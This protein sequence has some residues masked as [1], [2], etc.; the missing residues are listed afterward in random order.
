VLAEGLENACL[1]LGHNLVRRAAVGRRGRDPDVDGI[2]PGNATISLPSGRSTH[3]PGA[4]PFAFGIAVA[5]G[6][7]QACF[8]FVA[9]KGIARR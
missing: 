1:D 3:Q 6:V 7:S 5:E 2:G 9:G 4:V 8:T